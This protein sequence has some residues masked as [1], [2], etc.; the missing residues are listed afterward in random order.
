MR[1]SQVRVLHGSSAKE[2]TNYA[3]LNDPLKTRFGNHM[4][5][6]RAQL[7]LHQLRPRRF[8]VKPV[9]AFSLNRTE[10]VGR[11]GRKTR[12][13]SVLADSVVEVFDVE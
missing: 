1:G 12:R 7:R 5:T 10:H 6:N 8:L 2:S 11:V 9:K 13:T 4:A 3:A